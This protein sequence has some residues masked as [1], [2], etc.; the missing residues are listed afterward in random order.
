MNGWVRDPTR[1]KLIKFEPNLESKSQSKPELKM[2][3]EVLLNDIFYPHG[4]TLPSCFNLPDIGP[5]VTFELR[6]HYTQMLPK[7]TSLEDAYLFLR[8]F[9]EVCFM[10]HFPNISIDV[11]HMKLISFTLKDTIKR[12]TYGLAANSVIS[13]D[14]FVKLFLRKYFLMPKL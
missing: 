2:K 6:T 14:D 3:Q 1:R 7:F 12:W 9:K 13:W 10:I 4:T 11:V 8:E 5:N